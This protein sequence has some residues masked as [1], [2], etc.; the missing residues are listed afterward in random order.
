MPLNRCGRLA[1]IMCL[2]MAPC[3]GAEEVSTPSPSSRVRITA[4]P[5]RHIVGWLLPSSDPQL[6]TVHTGRRIVSV[7]RES[8]V[9]IEQS[10]R[11]SKKGKGLAIGVLSGLAFAGIG[12]GDDAAVGSRGG[13]FALLAMFTV[14]IGA[15]IGLAVSP[16]E[17]WAPASA[18]AHERSAR[19]ACG[20]RIAF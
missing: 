4:T 18:P 13:T 10:I 11:R 14:P 16:G 17:R 8:V 6:L 1:G 7:N 2:F 3:I 9:N 20:L 15:G 12:A 5:R 19:P